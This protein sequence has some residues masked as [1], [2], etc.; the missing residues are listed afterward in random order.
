[1]FNNH[2]EHQSFHS[3]EKEAKE[4][5]IEIM[6]EHLLRYSWTEEE[7]DQLLLRN[8]ECL[9]LEKL[10]K[11]DFLVF[12]SEE[13]QEDDVFYDQDDINTISSAIAHKRRQFKEVKSYL[14]D[15]EDYFVFIT[16]INLTTKRRKKDGEG[17]GNFL[18]EDEE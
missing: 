13:E 7:I 4:K 10:E 8:I 1:M 15:E 3:T 18:S 6:N 5:A 2:R 16:K 11:G 14:D 17:F 9:K 12:F